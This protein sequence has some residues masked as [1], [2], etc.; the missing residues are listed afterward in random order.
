MQPLA[1][2]TILVTGST[3][4]IGKETARQLARAGAT[5]IVHGRSAE[6]CNATVAALRTS[7]RNERIHACV[8]DLSALRAVRDL[9]GEVEARFERLD[10]LVNNAGIGPGPRTGGRQVSVDGYELRFAV[11]YLAPF[12]LTRLL[13]PLLKQSTPSRIV[14]VV[15]GAQEAIDFKDVM[16]VQRYEPMR[17]YSQSKLALVMLTFD[18]A[19]ELR[20]SGVTANC[21]HPGSLLDTKMVRETFGTAWGKPEDGARAIAWLASAAELNGLTGR[22]FDV[23]RETRADAQAYDQAARQRLRDMTTAL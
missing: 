22:Y 18:L 23:E 15:S 17:A 8:A 12:L 3:D 10:V 2:W 7:T 5:T 1:E 13:L 11:N 20:G 21:L 16:L 6:R 19:D 9:A 4:G 14:N